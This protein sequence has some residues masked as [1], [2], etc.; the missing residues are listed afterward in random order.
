LER[1]A[2]RM[3]WSVRCDV[4]WCDVMEWSHRGMICRFRLSPLLNFV[5]CNVYVPLIAEWI[6][7][8]AFLWPNAWA[9]DPIALLGRHVVDVGLEGRWNCYT[10]IGSTRNG[11]VNAIRVASARL[12]WC[13]L[14]VTSKLRCH[15]ITGVSLGGKHDFPSYIIVVALTLALLLQKQQLFCGIPRHHGDNHTR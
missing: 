10:S 12:T 7:S 6:W 1:F 13:V 4:M 15:I 2:R 3:E 5:I 11:F 14:I 8:G 9:G